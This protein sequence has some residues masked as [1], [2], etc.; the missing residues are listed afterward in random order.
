MVGVF[1]SLHTGQGSQMFSL[2]G[3][4]QS[5]ATDSTYTRP[6]VPSP[7]W[8]PSSRKA[9]TRRR[10]RQKCNEPPVYNLPATPFPVRE[11]SEVADT[12][13]FWSQRTSIADCIH[14]D[15]LNHQLRSGQL[16]LQFPDL[17]QW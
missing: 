11:C 1:D 6:T 15:P 4:L 3:H 13:L 9:D 16:T 17:R 14:F 5:V 12:I 10:T 8:T 7:S 2:T